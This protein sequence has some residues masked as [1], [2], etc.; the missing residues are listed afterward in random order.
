MRF[1]VSLLLAALA[2]LA[3]ATAP[4]APRTLERG[5]LA[6]GAMRYSANPL[7]RADARRLARESGVSI[8]RVDAAWRDI[9]PEGTRRPAGFDATDPADP[10]YDFA[11]LDQT[12]RELSADGFEP[13][14]NITFA[15]RWAEGS[16]RP[17][18]D[19][20]TR[21]GT[22]KPSPRELGRFMRAA[23]RRYSG[24]F[25]GLPRVRRWQVWNEPNLYVFL[26]PQWVRR[27]P[28][29]PGHYARMLDAAYA[30]IKAVRHSNFVVMGGTAPFGGLR[31]EANGRM[32]PVQFL[33][34]MLRSRP[35]V[36]AFAHHPYSNGGPARR[37][38]NRDDASLPDLG[39]LRRVAAR[40]RMRRPLWVTEMGWDSRPPDPAG[41]PLATHGRWLSQALYV[42]WR[43][44]VPVALNLHL[45]DAPLGPEAPGAPQRQAGL[46]L[47]DFT[48][49]PAATAFRFPF[50]V[51]GRR[52]W[53]VSPCSCNVNVEQRVRG[54][55]VVLRRARV[56]S[57]RV[58]VLRVRLRGSGALRARAGSELSLSLGSARL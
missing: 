57:G 4:A 34:E 20:R 16:G 11:E 19:A 41:V 14:L 31:P 17:G 18:D 15:P 32:A 22:W 21:A 42:L 40:A 24:S 56:R 37:A 3:P 43:Q 36:D 53:G 23:A 55:W 10:L 29:A 13:L 50:A 30:A 28:Y 51:D 54:R 48:P 39:K 44:S 26:R 7:A 38:L 27:R 33:R 1:R 35:R 46:F 9:A 45:A 5:V 58:F 47:L 25:Q 52:A 12:L 49:K 2:A 8:V 6:E